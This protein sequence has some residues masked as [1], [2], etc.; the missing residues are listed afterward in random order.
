MPSLLHPNIIKA[1]DIRGTWDKDLQPEDVMYIAGCFAAYITDTGD[2]Q[3][4]CIGRDGRRSSLAIYYIL[5]DTF[6]A[7][8]IR[9]INLGI[10]HTPLLYF[11]MMDS[12][13]Y[14]EYGTTPMIGMMITGSHN[15]VDDNGLKIVTRSRCLDGADIKN[16]VNKYGIISSTSNYTT[17]TNMVACDTYRTS[18][19][20]AMRHKY[21]DK[22]QQ[23]A[24]HNMT[25][26][27]VRQI[28]NASGVTAHSYKD[29]KIAWDAGNGA[30]SVILPKLLSI[31]DAQHVVINNSIDPNFT[32]RSPNPIPSNLHHIQHKVIDASCDFGFAFDGDGDRIVMILSDGRILTGGELLYVLTC[33]LI[34]RVPSPRV[35][36]D[37]KMSETII[38]K[39]RA[40]GADVILSATGHSIIKHQMLKYEAHIAGEM[41]GHIYCKEN[42]YNFEDPL[43]TACKIIEIHRRDRT[44]ICATL[45]ELPHLCTHECRVISTPSVNHSIISIVR[46]RIATLN[47]SYTAI[48]GIRVTMDGGY[49]LIRSSNT[50]DALTILLEYDSKEKLYKS[51][52]VL[53]K[54]IQEA[55]AELKDCA[56][57]AQITGPHK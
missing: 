1:Y 4:V 7:F 47:L 34:K 33:D 11:T 49:W 30:A 13:T 20:C 44:F 3:T 54:A 37:I 24:A 53:Y 52:T 6:T 46:E 15:P 12:A 17:T 28:T 45:A 51:W 32:C 22:A 57:L 9:T 35:I 10:V 25:V 41:S 48:D 26:Q 38:N 19:G 21:H 29:I 56:F 55:A 27:Y 42:Y 31:V 2:T 14:L 16:I 50:E 8:G 39:L 5:H 36:T 40:K 23:H 18:N 43:Y